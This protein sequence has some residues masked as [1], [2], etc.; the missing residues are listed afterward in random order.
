MMILSL[1]I[2]VATGNS[3]ETGQTEVGTYTYY[4]TQSVDGCESEPLEIS[5]NINAK[6]EATF[7]PLDAVCDTESAFTLSG[8]L[9]DGGEY[10]GTGVEAGMFSPEITGAGTFN[11]SYIYIDENLCSDTAYQDIIVNE[12][13]VFEL[14]SDTA[15]CADLT[16]TLDATAPN[17]DSYLWSPGNETTASITVDSAGFGIGSQEFSVLVT[18][19]NGC[20]NTKS[21]TITFEDC[22]GIKEIPGL[23]SVSIYPNP[24]KGNF[25]LN[26]SAKQNL[27]ADIQIVNSAGMVEYEEKNVTIDGNYQQDISLGQLEAGIYY[28]SLRNKD[29]VALKKIVVY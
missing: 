11:I 3:F 20:T 28:L 17:A 22:A 5:L 14:G 26:V 6:P 15:I 4:S 25:T 7:A 9:P 29:G 18:G 2:V 10:M 13:P 1:P 16:Y 27:Q 8:G 12:T 19:V 23:Q 24:N 21:L